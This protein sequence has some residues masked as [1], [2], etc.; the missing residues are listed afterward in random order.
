MD[1]MLIEL[2]DPTSKHLYQAAIDKIERWTEIVHTL[3]IKVSFGIGTI[4]WCVFTFLLYFDAEPPND[5]FIVRIHMKW[6]PF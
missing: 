6:V 4:S 2:F 1:W 5:A 3:L